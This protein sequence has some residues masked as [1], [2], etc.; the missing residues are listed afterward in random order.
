MVITFQSKNYS[1]E[2]VTARYVRRSPVDETYSFCEVGQDRR[3]DLRQGK[4]DGSD[5]P[6]D[7]RSQADAQRDQAFGYVQWP[8]N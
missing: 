3:W 4:V 6:D 5:L 2:L 8:M 7:I 1:P